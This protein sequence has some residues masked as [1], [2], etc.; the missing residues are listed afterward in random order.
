MR[1]QT[2]EAFNAYKAQVAQLNGVADVAEKF[3][4]SESVE[5]TIETR[6]MESAEFL[7][8]V[9]NV[10]VTEQIGEKIGIGSNGPIAG[11]TDTNSAD[12]ATS[13][14]ANADGHKYICTQTNF[15]THIRYATLDA[16]AKFPDF[17]ARVRDT[18]IRQQALDRIM[19]GF[20]GTSAAATTNKAS[21]TLLQ[22]VNIGWLKKL[23]TEAPARY[24]TQGANAGE[25][26][27]GAGSATLLADYKNVAALV[28]D[29]RTNLLDPWHARDSQFK[30]LISADFEQEIIAGMISSYAEVPTEAN[31]LA[32]LLANGK[33]L[34]LA[35]E[36]VP[37]FPARTLMIT[38]LGGNG[39]SNLSIYAQSGSRR[40]TIIDNPKRD[41]IE[42][43][44]SVNEAYVIEDLGAACAAVNIKLWNGTAFA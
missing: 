8:K 11:R 7:G 1:T 27:I 38:R 25:I 5:Q 37:Y 26:R 35:V 42:N 19:I 34:G 21:N 24:M 23:Q 6:I 18:I 15:D 13:D 2:R 28:A 32:Q 12:R 14:A 9:N 3:A 44:E 4:V 20:N 29:M 16:Y 36:V 39:E 40:R 17:Q 31:A 43:Y 10:L 22:D 41:R 33:Y 30:V